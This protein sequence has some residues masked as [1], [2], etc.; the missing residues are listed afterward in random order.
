[1]EERNDGMFEILLNR[2]NSAHAV[3]KIVQDLASVKRGE[4]SKFD[5]VIR[6]YMCFGYV[7]TRERERA[8]QMRTIIG[9]GNGGTNL[10][11]LFQFA[12]D[13]FSDAGALLSISVLQGNMQGTLTNKKIH[14]YEVGPSPTL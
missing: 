11:H 12:A 7:G 3:K 4:S 8:V 9:G 6:A 13:Q 1:M 14:D 2:A 5:V 10:G